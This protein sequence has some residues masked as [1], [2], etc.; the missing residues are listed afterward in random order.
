MEFNFI[1]LEKCVDGHLYRINA[2]NGHYG[3]FN[4]DTGGFTLA[5]GKFNNLFL[6]EE[7]HWDTG[8]PFGTVKLL[9]DLGEIDT[10][11]RKA[12]LEYLNLLESGYRDGKFTEELKR[13]V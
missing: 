13:S 3:V 11:D 4:Q 6:F 7:F 2:R 5:R 12:L 1:F 9:G 8:P 10:K